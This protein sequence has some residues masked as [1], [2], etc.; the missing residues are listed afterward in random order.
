[1]ES[2]HDARIDA[3][4]RGESHVREG[5]GSGGNARVPG[6]VAAAERLIEL[7][8]RE[9]KGLGEERATETCEGL[10]SRDNGL[11]P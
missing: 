6:E 10:A 5:P 3:A 8:M 7:A 4:A 1:M 2:G 9:S 11:T